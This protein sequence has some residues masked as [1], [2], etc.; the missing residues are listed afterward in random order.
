MREGCGDGKADQAAA[1][2]RNGDART[3][4]VTARE[5]G[6]GTGG[7]NAAMEVGGVAKS[8]ERHFGKLKVVA[9]RRMNPILVE[10][11]RRRGRRT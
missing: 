11:G 6:V 5:T 2:G 8:R 10:I 4:H 3:N 1:G 7:D 9:R